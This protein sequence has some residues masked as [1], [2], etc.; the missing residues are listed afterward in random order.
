MCQSRA[1]SDLGLHGVSHLRLRRVPPRGTARTADLRLIDSCITQLKA[2]RPSRTCNASKEEEEDLGLHGASHLGLRRVP[3]RDRAHQLL[4]L[5]CPGAALRRSLYGS[6]LSQTL[7]HR[8]PKRPVATS[9]DTYIYIY[10]YIHTYI[11][12][13]VYIYATL[14]APRSPASAPSPAHSRCRRL[15]FGGGRCS[16]SM[17]P[18]RAR[19]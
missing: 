10:I 11:C 14:P 4:H 7:N 8:N 16:T 6:P 2:Q 13:Y 17:V 1:G 9:R 3:P 19:I 18:R 15:S 5:R 12:I